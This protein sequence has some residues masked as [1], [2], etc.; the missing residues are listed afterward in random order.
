MLL[1][2]SGYEGD[3]HSLSTEEN[4]KRPSTD[5]KD[6]AFESEHAEDLD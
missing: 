3:R 6:K 1:L 5:R 4:T 2:D